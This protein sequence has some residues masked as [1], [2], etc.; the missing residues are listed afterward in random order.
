MLVVKLSV[1]MHHRFRRIL[2]KC[3]P[4]PR[5][6]DRLAMDFISRLLEKSPRRRLGRKGAEEIKRHPFLADIDW[7][8][9]EKK[10]LVPPI[11]PT[12]RNDV[13]LPFYGFHNSSIS[14]S[15]LYP[16]NIE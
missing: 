10:R 12:I 2:S 16:K 8:K 6:F 13:L 11:I 14:S 7:D 1:A 5:D 15:T 9:C 3:V 4:F